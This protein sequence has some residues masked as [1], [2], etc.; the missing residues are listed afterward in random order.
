MQC[1]RRIFLQNLTGFAVA[2][3][4]G[5]SGKK[6]LAMNIK[7][8]TSGCGNSAIIPMPIQVVIDD[9]GWWSGRDGSEKDEP[10]R[11]GINRNHVVAD[12]QAIIQLGRALG[13]RP[14]AAMVLCEWDRENI[15]RDLPES[16]WMGKEWDNRQWV[17]PWLEEAADLIRNN[18]DHFELTLHG[19]GHEHWT[20]G[21]ISRAEWSTDDGTMRPVKQVNQH[22]D[23]YE[24]IMR[25]NQLGSF[26]LSF[27][28]AA[29][30]HGFGCTGDH[31]VS[32]AELLDKKG[33]DYINT[34]FYKMQNAD[35]IENGLFGMDAGVLTVNRGTDL[36]NWDM[37]GKLPEGELNGPTCGMHWPNILH[38]DPERNSEIVKGWVAFLKPYNYR[39]ETI[40]AK[41]SLHFQK[42]LLHHVSTGIKIEGDMIELDFSETDSLG[43][44]KGRSNLTVKLRNR[45]QK[46]FDSETLDI[47][48]LEERREKNSIL[49]TLVLRRMKIQDK[50]FIR[51][52]SLT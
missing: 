45:D 20:D 26:P 2:V 19:I 6:L 14:Q 28:P 51:F 27:V 31:S 39:Y 22:L 18:P 37:I 42:Q 5:A 52:S 24:K 43:T 15:L 29:F 4:L 12:Y 8:I 10:Y 50:S 34:P 40:L 13:I 46:S 44:D 41:D 33:I 23:Y 32:L 49:Y 38:P 3:G 21:R 47:L 7:G 35:E 9:V 25:Q 16:T 30:N 1:N 17:G 11:T 48:S 36:Q